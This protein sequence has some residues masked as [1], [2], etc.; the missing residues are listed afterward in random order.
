MKCFKEV[1]IH[2]FRFFSSLFGPI[3]IFF[4]HEYFY[5]FLLLYGN[6]TQSYAMSKML[7]GFY[8]YLGGQLSI[9]RNAQKTYS[10]THRGL[11]QIVFTLDFN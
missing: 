8:F 5:N 10:M 4:I 3:W 2:L 9:F 6:T 1:W 7:E 11:F